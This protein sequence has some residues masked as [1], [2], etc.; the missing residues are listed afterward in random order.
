MN[1][2]GKVPDHGTLSRYHGTTGVPACRCEPCTTRA[3]REKKLRALERF[4]GRPRRVSALPVRRHI[5][6]LQQRG[7]TYAQIARA[8]G[9]YASSIREIARGNRQHT[10]RKAAEAVFAVSAGCSVTDGNVSAVGV[11]RRLRALYAI[12]IA[13]LVLVE[14]TGLCRETIDD[15]V[16][17]RWERI[18]VRRVA[19]VRAAYDRLWMSPGTSVKARKR[20]Q[21]EGWAGPLH[22]D[23]ASID[24]PDGFP[25]WTGAC[26]TPKGYK[27]HSRDAS[28]PPPCEPCKRAAQAERAAVNAEL[29]A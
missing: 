16:A 7:L 13:Q 17:G 11:V 26:G 29:A 12:G 6:R 24:D 1:R 14:S 25:D 2:E 22:W 23:D 20:A 27:Q 18:N 5:E 21:R 15:L 9:L 4:A 19:A 8:S 28:L 3:V 10:N